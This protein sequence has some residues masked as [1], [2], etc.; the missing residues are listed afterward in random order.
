M[1]TKALDS[2]RK[3]PSSGDPPTD[4]I[5]HVLSRLTFGPTPEQRER[6]AGFEPAEVVRVLL[7]DPPVEVSYPDVSNYD[8]EDAVLPSLPEWWFTVMADPAAGVHERMVWFWHGLITSSLDKASPPDMLAQHELL[9]RNAL[10]NFRTL[11][12]EITVDAAMLLW[13]DGADSVAEDPNENYAREVMELFSLGRHSGAYTE[14]DVKAGA[15][16]LAGY[17]VD[18]EV[19]NADGRSN[20]VFEPEL[21]L[22]RPVR[23]LGRRV[24]TAADVIDAICDH[25]MC[26]RYI[27]AKVHRYFVGRPP[28]DRRLGALTDLFRDADLEIAPLVEA[29]VTHGSFLETPTPRPASPVEWLLTVSRLLEVPIDESSFDELGQI[30]FLPPNVAGWPDRSRWVSAA[31]AISKADFVFSRMWEAGPLS[32]TDPVADV[33]ARAG[34]VAVSDSTRRVLE[35]VV[36][37]SPDHEMTSAVLRAVIATSPELSIS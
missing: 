22:Q 23:Y 29:I 2:S 18:E 8:D 28:S 17:W 13:L 15:K 27:A 5:G 7:G 26:P 1:S 34:L 11:L 3:S 36:D 19:G 33:I 30:P 31:T 14:A 37:D 16:A 12:Q 21:A 6:F 32:T 4:P 24:R 25:P 20:V 10:S 35:Q 9:R